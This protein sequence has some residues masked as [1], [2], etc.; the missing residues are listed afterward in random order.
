[1]QVRGGSSIRGQDFCPVKILLRVAAVYSFAWAIVL[2]F[3]AWLSFG[4]RAPSPEIIAFA[5]GLAIANLGLAY[6]FF[7]AAIEPAAHR[8][9]LYSALAIF[10]LRGV[11]GTYEVLFVL[12]GPP[13]M[14]RLI[15]FVLSLALFVGI[16][17]SLP[18]TLQGS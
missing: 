12:D 5:H 8:A 18:E 16:L 1:L 15:D 7:R 3:P 4:A 14:L 11:V 2:A 9:I 13:A 17:N 10:G 6:L